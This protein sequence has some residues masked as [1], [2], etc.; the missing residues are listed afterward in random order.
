V[1]PKTELALLRALANAVGDLAEYAVVD[2]V[3][4]HETS[5]SIVNCD[6]LAV[7]KRAYAE[8]QLAVSTREA[9]E[10][11]EKSRTVFLRDGSTDILDS[12]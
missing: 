7:A 3:G 6:K 2:P 10:V 5:V 11:K 4:H 9:A 1:T 8:W 12:R